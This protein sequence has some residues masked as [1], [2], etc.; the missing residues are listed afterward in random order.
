MPELSA[1][2]S[3]NDSRTQAL[4]KSI[5]PGVEAA[6]RTPGKAKTRPGAAAEAPAPEKV[7]VLI[8]PPRWSL[9]RSPRSD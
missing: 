9:P 6:E 3:I 1:A 7:A 4:L 8:N 2:P 5:A